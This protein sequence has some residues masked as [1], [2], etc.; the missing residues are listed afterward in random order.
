[1]ADPWR[2]MVL[3]CLAASVFLSSNPQAVYA[4]TPDYDP[5]FYYYHPDHLGSSQLMTDR[6]GD[7]VQHYGYSPFG[8]ENYRNNTY[9]FSVSNRYTGQQLDEDTGLYYYGARYYD[10]ELARFIQADSTIPDPEFS[11]AYNRYA[12]VYNNPLK[13]SDP[14]GQF[15]W[16]I[17]WAIVEATV[18]ALPAIMISTMISASIA[19]IAGANPKDAFLGSLTAGLGGFLFGAIA[20]GALAAAVTGG[21][22]VQGA[23]S[24]GVSAGVQ[25]TLGFSPAPSRADFLSGEYL[26][27][28]ALSTAS[29]SVCGGV[30]AEVLGGDFSEGAVSGASSAASNYIVW[31]ALLRMSTEGNPQND[32][33]VADFLAQ[34]RRFAIDLAVSVAVKIW[35]SPNTALGLLYGFAG[36]VLGGDWPV[37]A[38]AGIHFPNSPLQPADTAVTMGN[39]AVY[40]KGQRIDP[41]TGKTIDPYND[42]R[43]HETQHMYQGEVLGPLYFPLHII[44]KLL[45]GLGPKG[46]LEKGPYSTPPRPWP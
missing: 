37:F 16:A 40:G 46:W 2:Q 27:D 20:G 45:N 41:K 42:Y 3:L 10:P 33:A 24:G 19:C 6:D 34:R 13:F 18:E 43:S 26:I 23:I 15:P 17:A 9:A 14:T 28:L 7:V 8:R 22:P 38:E 21:D 4:G 44:D 25:I 31:S 39:I 1:M 30:T 11:Q 36:V 5:V 35:N 29:G 12:Y 32:S